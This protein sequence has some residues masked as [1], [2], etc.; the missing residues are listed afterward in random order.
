MRLGFRGAVAAVVAITLIPSLASAAAR[1]DLA[2]ARATSPEA[3]SGRAV[4][5]PQTAARVAALPASPCTVSDNVRT[6]ELWARPGTLTLP[7]GSTPAS[8]PIWGYSAS[9]SDAVTLPAPLL[10]AEMGQTVRVT[11]HNALSQPASLALPEQNLPPDTTG[12]APGATKTYEF[13]AAKPGT[14]TYEAGLTGGGPRQ[15]AM[16]LAGAFI[17]APTAGGTAYGSP[18][19]SYDDE[20]LLVLQAVDP[21][22]NAAPATFAMAKYRPRFWLINGRAYPETAP[23]GTAAGHRL[24]LRYVNAGLE[25]HPMSLAGAYQSVIAGDGRPLRH[26]YTVL[27]GNI[28]PG[29][30]M[31]AL[32][33]VPAG[34]AAETRLPLYDAARRIHNAGHRTGGS[35]DFGGMLTFV[36]VGP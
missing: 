29:G 5:A 4:T 10:L 6:C 3:A 7:A 13:T 23:V 30:T 1:P 9:A 25:D 36:T 27:S 12:V 35:T 19:T 16:G 28:A 33:S 14:F 24:L 2:P 26:P 34:L 18:A 31:D 17:V 21:A 8:V 20:A 32:V 11:L 22:L 15:V